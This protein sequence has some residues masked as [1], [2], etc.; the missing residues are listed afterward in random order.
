MSHLYMYKP[1]ASVP[2]AAE[3]NPDETSA[4]G[5]DEEA[6]VYLSI[7]CGFLTVLQ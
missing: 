6:P 7:E 3:H 4:A 5:P 2:I 1:P